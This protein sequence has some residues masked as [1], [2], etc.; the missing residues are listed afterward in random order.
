MK[1][2][3]LATVAVVVFTM[4]SCT[5]D[6]ILS[7]NPRTEPQTIEFSTYT[8][9]TAQS[10][11]TIVDNSNLGTYGF[12][13]LAYYTGD[14]GWSEAKE[15]ATPNFMYNQLV[16][17]ATG[18]TS[19]SYSPI[20]YWPTMDEDKI[21]F[22]AYAPYDDA[23][24]DYG[25]QLSANSASGLPTAEF[26]VNTD[27]TKMVDFVTAG[28]IDQMHSVAENATEPNNVSFTF[29]HALTRL[30][31]QAKLSQNL[32]AQ[33]SYVIVRKTELLKKD[34]GG[35]FYSKAT[36]TFDDEINEYQITFDENFKPVVTEVAKLTLGS[37]DYDNATAITND[38]DI[39]R[40]L[41]KNN[42]A[43]G[44]KDEKYEA[45]QGLQLT[46]DTPVPMFNAQEATDGLQYLFLIPVSAVNGNG[47]LEGAASIRFEYDIVTVDANL[48]LGYSK[49]TATKSVNLPGGI[50]K[51]G[52]AYNLTFI[53]DVDD[54]VVAADVDTWIDGGSK[55]TDVPYSPDAPESNE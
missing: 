23:S 51:Q 10:R 47:L 33:K 16:K 40:I 1:K 34:E 2:N 18:A 17:K 44:A 36:Y 7:T 6:E 21:S 48:D 8:G 14:K 26:T 20:K 45:N 28:A 41:L 52:T 3:Y 35:K 22:F 53:F 13:V 4:S 50:M 12:G 29:K 11:G 19:W 25:I 38:W 27:P 43:L 37:W 24:N 55:E 15:N 39:T 9:N 32:E 49:T 54:I 31:F 30:A 42:I 5:Q 46:T